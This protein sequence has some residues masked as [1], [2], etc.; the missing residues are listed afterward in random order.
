[1]NF[2]PSS[3]QFAAPLKDDDFELEIVE[4]NKPIHRYACSLVAFWE[5]RQDAGG[6][7][8]GR[9]IPSRALA[10]ILPFIGVYEPAGDDDYYVRLAGSNARRYFGRDISHQRLSELGTGKYS[11]SV[12]PLL[13]K[14]LETQKPAL[15]LFH[16][17]KEDQTMSREMAILPVL[18]PEG[19][20]TWLLL[21]SFYRDQ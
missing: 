18:S 8:M 17:H 13:R 5:S 15:S 2:K 4:L 14:P 10:P 9:D 21:G 6:L 11:Q 1:L 12:L 7:R 20:A 3:F 19:T 16:M